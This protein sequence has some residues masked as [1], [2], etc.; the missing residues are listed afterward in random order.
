[1][2]TNRK[3]PRLVVNLKV[4]W[5]AGS[6]TGNAYTLDVSMGGAFLQ[7]A[8][9]VMVGE[10]LQ[11]LFQVN[12]DGER[13][14]VQCI[15]QV[16]RVLA[17]EQAAASGLLP[18]FAVEFRRFL[19]GME[20]LR[21][22]LAG[23]LGLSLEQVGHAILGPVP[24]H[25]APAGQGETL[26]SPRPVRS[27]VEERTRA[28]VEERIRAPVEERIRAPVE[29]RR[30]PVVAEATPEFADATATILHTRPAARGADA[31]VV[32][33]PS[34]PPDEAAA[35]YRVASSSELHPAIGLEEAPELESPVEARPVPRPAALDTRAILSVARR[36][37]V[38]VAVLVVLSWVLSRLGLIPWDLVPWSLL[39]W[40]PAP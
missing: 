32:P 19:Q 15:G 35:A 9:T 16:R 4:S 27:P 38:V 28:P 11:L 12:L 13:R 20:D 31:V 30:A 29:E 5:R 22:F 25:L 26:A 3:Q 23:R 7:T 33:L 24:E 21:S 40:K 1:M 10:W 18:G 37:A 39:P 34:R 14:P 2:Q 8:D 17:R 6:R 36:T